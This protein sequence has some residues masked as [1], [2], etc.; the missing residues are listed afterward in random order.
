MSQV[1]ST[2]AKRK[3]PCLSADETEL[4]LKINRG[5]SHDM[6]TRFDELVVKRQAETL[7]HQEHQELLSLTD[8]IEKS[9]AERI[10]NLAELASIRGISLDVLMEELDIHPPAYD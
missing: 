7:T 5:L 1:V 4:M 6:Q 10:K 8:Q 2:Q 9:D 3:S